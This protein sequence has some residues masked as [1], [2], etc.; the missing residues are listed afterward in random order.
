MVLKAKSFGRDSLDRIESKV[1]ALIKK[2]QEAKRAYQAAF[3][4]TSG[5]TKKAEPADRALSAEDATILK[6]AVQNL[7]GGLYS[8]ALYDEMTVLVEAGY[9]SA[10]EL[11]DLSAGYDVKQSS[12]MAELRKH[13]NAFGNLVNTREQTMLVD[14]IDE[15]LAQGQ[16]PS[17]LSSKIQEAFSEGYHVYQDGQLE[18]VV[19]S[20]DWSDMVAR[21]ELSRAQTMGA[22]SLYDAAGVQQVLFATTQGASVC[23]ECSDLDGETLDVADLDDDNTPPIHPNCCCVLIPADADLTGQDDSTDE[24]AA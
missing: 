11:L 6:E 10:K 8:E 19:A 18:R 13:T 9:A 15:A 1:P 20:E 24:E 16:T 4:A 3:W 23:P 2:L 12:A 7:D 14:L 5:L 22:L 17:E 21:T